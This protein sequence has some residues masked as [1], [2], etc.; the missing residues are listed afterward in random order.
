MVLNMISEIQQSDWTLSNRSPNAKKIDY[1]LPDPL[2]LVRGRD[3]GTRLHTC[4]E[5]L[6]LF[7]EEVGQ[8]VR[9]DVIY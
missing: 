8:E 9:P 2:S 1:K 5:P 3:L 6:P 7:P 4:Y